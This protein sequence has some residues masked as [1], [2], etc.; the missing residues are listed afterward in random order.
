MEIKKELDNL[1][2][3]AIVDSALLHG[4]DMVVGDAGFP[5]RG[6]DPAGNRYFL[7]TSKEDERVMNEALCSKI[8]NSKYTTVAL[9]SSSLVDDAF[10]R[11]RLFYVREEYFM[12]AA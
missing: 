2:A 4:V 1:L 3:G 11:K 12:K 5:V 10:W 7:L 8:A 9:T 6:I